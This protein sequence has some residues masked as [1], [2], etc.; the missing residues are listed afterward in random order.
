ML[1]GVEAAK[2][3]FEAHSA[4]P[5]PIR[6]LNVWCNGWLLGDTAE[7]EGRWAQLQ[8]RRGE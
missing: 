1:E 2:N 3:I 4:A 7:I 5:A 6:E 8:V